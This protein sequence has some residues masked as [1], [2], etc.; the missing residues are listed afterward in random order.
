MSTKLKAGDPLPSV[1]MRA[2]DGY[3]L[4]LRSWVG[5]QPVLL[6]FFDSSTLKGEA[7][8]HG[9]AIMVALRDDHARLTQAGVAVAA[10]SLD[11]EQGQS[12]YVEKHRL[13]FLLLS[14]ERRS[15]VELLGIETKG[16][17]GSTKVA[18]PLA[19][20]VGPDGV[21]RAVID[22]I[23]APSLVDRTIREVSKP[24]RPRTEEDSVGS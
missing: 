13:P 11:S 19:F 12:A 22:P 16:A 23:D 1:G 21:I 15:A 8:R 10:I 2:T 5:K 24:I 14:D 4:N 9:D 20:V 17:G 6:L 18:R 7:A 3:L